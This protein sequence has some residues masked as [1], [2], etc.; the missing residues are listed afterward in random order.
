MCNKYKFIGAG[1]M[2]TLFSVGAQ[3]AVIVDYS[4]FT[5]T[6][7]LS[8]IGSANTASTSDGGSP[9]FPVAATTYSIFGNG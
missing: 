2:S 3:A 8:L 1:V 7:G 6:S 9:R 4:D 5:N